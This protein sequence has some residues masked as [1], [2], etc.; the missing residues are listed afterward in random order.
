MKKF[1]PTYRCLGV[2]SLLLVGGTL[3]GCNKSGS[4]DSMPTPTP[5]PTSSA[6]M[7][8]TPT[9]TAMVTPT[10]TSAAMVTPTPTSQ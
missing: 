9:S 10:P 6:M 2:L 3:A 8:P 1:S 5:T 4:T 7:T